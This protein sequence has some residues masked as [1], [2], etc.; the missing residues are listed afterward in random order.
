MIELQNSLIE[1]IILRKTDKSGDFVIKEP[2]PGAKLREIRFKKMPTDILAFTLDYVPK[3]TETSSIG[4]CK[5]LSWVF[6]LS[7]KNINK[8]C[9][10]VIIQKSKDDENHINIY[11]ADMK[12]EKPS[13]NSVL[14]QL[15]NTEVFCD[16]MLK[17]NSLYSKKNLIIE[18]KR[19]VFF[20]PKSM[21]LKSTAYNPRLFNR[22]K[23]RDSIN[24]IGLSVDRHGRSI[25][26]Y[27]YLMDNI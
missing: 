14:S 22:P 11:V 27:D 20:V 25:F 1:N 2:D 12:S 15:K 3:K 24:Y 17:L 10:L 19:I 7:A 18:F 21:A 5:S 13:H 23:K 6:K 4:N 26:N 8:K 16:F 9:D